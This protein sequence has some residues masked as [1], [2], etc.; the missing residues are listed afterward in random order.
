M[1]AC[2]VLPWSVG[3]GSI[4]CATLKMEAIFLNCWHHVLMKICSAIK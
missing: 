1:V 3:H 2:T 4:Y